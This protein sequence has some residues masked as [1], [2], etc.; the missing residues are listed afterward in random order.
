MGAADSRFWLGV[1]PILGVVEV[2]RSIFR[3]V[4]PSRPPHS[5]PIM[6]QRQQKMTKQGVRDL[7][8]GISKKPP[9]ATEAKTTSSTEAE[10][11]PLAVAVPHAVDAPVAE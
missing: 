1:W 10:V 7:D 2:C 6:E 4:E 11:V 9:A 5:V 8:F 3:M